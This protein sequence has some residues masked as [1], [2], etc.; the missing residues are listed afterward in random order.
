[1]KQL[2]YLLLFLV[3]P[4]GLIS[5]KNEDEP[6][7]PQEVEVSLDYAFFE[8]GSLTRSQSSE[9]IYTN[10]YERQLKT[11]KV[12][13]ATYSLSFS[14]DN[15]NVYTSYGWWDVNNTVT[16]LEGTYTVSGASCP[17]SKN[18][19]DISFG[20]DSVYMKFDSQVTVEKTSPNISLP[21]K[22]DCA[23]ILVPDTYVQEIKIEA[24]SDNW[25]DGT[26][27]YKERSI[28]HVDG[29]Y[30]FFY[31]DCGY[32]NSVRMTYKTSTVTNIINLECLKFEKGKYYILNTNTCS[33]DMPNLQP[34]S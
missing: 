12:C 31:K 6:K 16:L 29:V 1:M 30:Y 10:F 28:G 3:L 11:K 20:C 17:K 24:N 25:S 18:G 26:K 22:Y 8:S 27:G 15:K 32:S 7:A 34:G 4:L 19:I 33:F 14:A 23:L 9:E 2:S 13:P 21:A 5:C